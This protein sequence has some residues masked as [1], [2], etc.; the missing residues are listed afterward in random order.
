MEKDAKLQRA[1]VQAMAEDADYENMEDGIVRQ[2]PPAMQEYENHP[3]ADIFPKFDTS[4]L[5]GLAADIKANGLKTPITLYEG[6]ILDGR[7][8]YAACKL[9][10]VA[11][12]YQEY[13][14]TTPLQ[15]IISLN[16]HRRHL[17]VSQ[18]AAIAAKVANIKIG[19]VGKGHGRTDAPIGAPEKI[20]EYEAAKLLNV[21]RRTVQRVKRVTRK[22]PKKIADIETGK[23][24]VHKA[25]QEMKVPSIFLS[26]GREDADARRNNENPAEN[27]IEDSAAFCGLKRYWR[28]AR[29]WERQAFITWLKDRK[30]L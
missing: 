1:A 6:K 27:D 7:N 2:H 5:Q 22:A 23:K 12:K 28:Q 24:T 10:E 16:L 8:R 4:E 11:P 13:T 14:G 17:S 3:L 19:E 9:A 25:L 21:S 18:R 15:H 26:K 20:S 29:K 30:Q